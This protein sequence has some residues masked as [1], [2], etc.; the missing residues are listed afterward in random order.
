MDHLAFEVSSRDELREWEEGL[1]ERGIE[2]T[3]SVDTP[4]GTVV[5]FR[6]PDRIQ[7]EFWLP[8]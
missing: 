6:D 5:V 7:L 1:R 3:P 2:Y 4:I 8:I